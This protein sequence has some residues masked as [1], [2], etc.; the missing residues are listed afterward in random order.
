M[1]IGSGLQPARGPFMRSWTFWHQV[2]GSVGEQP[3]DLRHMS[4][5]HRW[6]SE[7]FIQ[8]QG[9][10]LQEAVPADGGFCENCANVEASG[11]EATG[12]WVAQHLPIVDGSTRLHLRSNETWHFAV[13]GDSLLS[14]ELGDV[15]LTE[16]GWWIERPRVT[17]ITAPRMSEGGGHVCEPCISNAQAREVGEQRI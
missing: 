14:D 5:C 12:E 15:F 13:A 10:G 11:N 17:A 7:W 1:G 9:G 8:Q 2:V 3:E 6:N 16:C 4:A